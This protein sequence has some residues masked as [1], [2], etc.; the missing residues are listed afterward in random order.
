MNI[1]FLT[2]LKIETLAD[3]GVY[4][5]LMRQFHKEGHNVF[6][7]TS[8]ERRFKQSTILCAGEAVNILKIRT[9]NFQKT[10]ILEK[11]VSTLLVN[12]QYSKAIRRFFPK[13]SFDLIL[14]STPPITFTRLVARLKK[15]NKSVSYLLLKDIFPQNAVDLGMIRRGGLFHKYLC[16]KEKKLYEVSDYIGCMSQANVDFVKRNN[17]EIAESKVEI[18]PNSHELFDEAISD[19]EKKR[20]RISHNIPE[21]TTLFIYGGNLGKPQGISFIIDF[22][23]AQKNNPEVFF[24]IIGSGTEYKRLKSWFDYEK[25]DNEILLSEL[26][27]RE[28]NKLLQSGD[29]GMIFLDGRFTVPNF[30]SRLLSYL[31]YKLPVIASTDINTDMGQTITENK[32]GLWSQSGDLNT[33]CQNVNRLAQN[34][35]LRKTM[36]LNG[37]NYFIQHYTV[38][39]SYKIIIRHF[40]TV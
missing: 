25:P 13:V 15:K 8:I 9:L 20:I 17:P 1:L 31:E 11:W 12:Y 24:V 30:P 23:A 7:V 28:Y 16:R 6:I 38:T 35:E 27:K 37:Y 14:Y 2:I 33:L 29:V 32:L 5:D 26:P 36:G 18:N 21:S 4:P 19:E 10:N 40:D 39:T 34:D 22:L 3:R